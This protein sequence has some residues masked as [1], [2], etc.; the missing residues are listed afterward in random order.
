MKVKKWLKVVAISIGGLLAF[1][2]I[3]VFV[4]GIVLNTSATQQKVLQY[5]VSYLSDKLETKVQ[6]DSVYIDVL[7]HRISLYGLD[8]EDQ[9]QRL[10]LAVDTLTVQLDLWK[11][12]KHEVEVEKA[13]LYGMDAHL[14]KPSPDEPSNYQFVIDAFSNKKDTSD[15]KPASDK[16]DKNISFDIHKVVLQRIHVTYND[17]EG[18]LSYF[19]LLKKKQGY[20]AQLHNLQ[21]QWVSNTKTGTKQNSVHLQTLELKPGNPMLLTFDG[22]HYLCDNGQPRKNTG[23]PNRGAFDTGHLDVTAH[24]EWELHQVSRDTI[25]ANLLHTTAIDSVSGIDLR[26]LR[27]ALTYHPKQVRLND[28]FLQQRST[29]LNIE[30]VDIQLADTLA[31]QPL[32]YHT[33]PITG[34]VILQDI[35]KLFAPT[36]SQF[37]MPLNLT[38]QMNGTA[39]GMTFCNVVVSTPDNRLNI[40]ANGQINNLKNG[41]DLT[42]CFHVAKMV[43]KG[44]VKEDILNQFKVTKLMQKQFDALG[45]IG[46]TGDFNVL[47]R[48]EE[49]RGT[50]TTQQGNLNFD[51]ALDGQNQYLVGS[52]NTSNFQL[53]HLFAVPALGPVSFAAHFK[54]DISKQR[55]AQMRR[56][57][58]GKLPIGSVKGTVSECS[59]KKVTL[60]NLDVDIESDGAEASG[61][62]MQRGRHVDIFCNFVMTST[63]SIRQVKVRPK[64]Q[65]HGLSEDDKQAK[66]EEKQQRREEKA[67]RKEQRRQERA[68]RKAQKAQ[69]SQN[70]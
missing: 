23:K 67:K 16:N 21:T 60:H 54:I 32:E 42:V 1:L 30:Q 63:D 22:L 17:N 58:G 15:T 49:F 3:A 56:Q 43:A 31:G 38:T 37:T 28:F 55:T 45:T 53:A 2:L 7:K 39:D 19:T 48:R 26:D 44:T 35:A 41:H 11:L 57:H 24:M 25:I 65:I 52:A 13:G 12:L 69:E 40:Q 62:V 9:Q 4:L 36:L 46:Y 6:A 68:D 47:W 18:L 27:F 29:T 70:E 64:L 66:E 33:T 51:F 5:A 10:M 50:L 59:Y 61:T 34:H 20:A 14:L 8:I